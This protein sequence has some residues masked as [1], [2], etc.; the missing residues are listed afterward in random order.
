V[1]TKNKQPTIVEVTEHHIR[2]GKRYDPGACPV[3]LALN[4]ALQT[5]VLTFICFYELDGFT[6]D[7]PL[8]ASKRI[9]VWDTYGVMKPFSFEV[10]HGC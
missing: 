1:Q 6:H 3:A 8:E 9:V 10:P 7:L 2:H 5:K 4:S